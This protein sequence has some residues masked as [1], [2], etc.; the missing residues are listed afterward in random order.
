MHEIIQTYSTA[1]FFFFLKTNY[2][3]FLK[4]NET[5]S[6]RFWSNIE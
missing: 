3:A 4:V 1:Y 2:F 6:A 5:V